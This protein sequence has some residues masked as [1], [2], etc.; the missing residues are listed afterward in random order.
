M[1]RS[2]DDVQ[3]RVTDLELRFM[4]LERFTNELSDAVAQQQKT[5]DALAAQ[6]RRLTE[7]SADSEESPLAERPPHY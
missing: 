3:A 6:V 5:I 2:T 7:R 1:N 4:K